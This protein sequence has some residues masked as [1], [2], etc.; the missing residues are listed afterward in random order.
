MHRENVKTYL[1][2]PNGASN[3]RDSYKGP[4]GIF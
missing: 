1:A 3:E 4:H 2:Q